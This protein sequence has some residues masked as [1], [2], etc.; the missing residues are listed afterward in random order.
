MARIDRDIVEDMHRCRHDL[1]A[2][3]EIAYAEIRTAALVAKELTACGLEVHQGLAGT[4]VVATLSRG[5]GPRIGLRADMDALAI[6]EATEL[7]YRSVVPGVMHACGHDGHTAMLLGAARQLSR[8]RDL[9]GV[10]HF[11]FQPAEE[12]E[13][14]ALRMLEQ[15]LLERF[16][17]D[18]IYAMHNWPGLPAGQFAVNRGAMMAA[19]DTFEIEIRGSGTHAAMPEMGCDPFIPVAQILLALQTI[20]SRR[21]NPQDAAVISVT[22]VHGG[23]TWN[24]IP[25]IVTLRGA[26]RCLSETVRDA[27]ERDVKSVVTAIAAAHGATARID[28]ARRYPVTINTAREAEFAATIAAAMETAMPVQIDGRASMASED[29]GFLLQKAPGAYLWLGAADD[30]HNMPLH[31]PFYDFNDELLEIGARY[32]VRLIE[33]ALSRSTPE[34]DDGVRPTVAEPAS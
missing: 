15:G 3:P 11:I 6:M 18:A 30:R 2:H 20:P 29:F 14:G 34:C 19:F 17:C 28:Y 22:Q 23:D 31:S 26:V 4:G 12:N 21:L 8:A 16:P 32:W 27:V 25:E 9:A 24:V 5:A 33:Q 13:G 10:V 7:P 1:H